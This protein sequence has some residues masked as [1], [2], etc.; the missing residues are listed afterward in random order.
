MV[1]ASTGKSPQIT[2]RNVSFGRGRPQAKWWLDN[3]PVPTAFYNALSAIFPQFEAFL[4][5]TVRSFRGEVPKALAED[6][7]G[8]I[9]QEAFHS[10]EHVAFNRRI[11]EAGYDIGALE[12][13]INDRV[14]EIRTHGMIACL[15]S[16]AASEHLTAILAHELLSNSRHLAHTSE[17]ARQLWQW[18]AMEEIEHKAV[19][20]D[21]WAYATKDWPPFRRWA[22]RCWMMVVTTRNFMVDRLAGIATL[23][24]QDGQAGVRNWARLFWYLYVNP[25]MMRRVTMAWLSYFRPGFHPW[26]HD[27]RH[28]I[29]AIDAKVR[30]RAED[31]NTAAA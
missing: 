13:R 9:R 25:G 14:A 27:D 23:L 1:P 17:D 5:D 2:P 24:K 28:L 7:Q 19:S 4:I 21:A 15:N 31:V 6:I 10:R 16:T 11:A 22:S 30:G 26:R 18:H 8:L 20:F 3:D 12:Q 29:A